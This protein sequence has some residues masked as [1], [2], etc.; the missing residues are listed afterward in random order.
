LWEALRDAE[1]FVASH[2]NDE[3]KEGWLAI[4]ELLKIRKALE[5]TR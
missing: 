5:E 3:S 4:G 1:T 2:C